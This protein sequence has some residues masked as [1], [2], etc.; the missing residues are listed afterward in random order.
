MQTGPADCGMRVS[1]QGE[2]MLEMQ[3]TLMHAQ[4]KTLSLK[5]QWQ[6]QKASCTLLVHASVRR[7][8]FP[9]V[10]CGKHLSAYSRKAL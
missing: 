9:A 6:Q 3:L 7:A 8:S 4:R 10:E 5:L 2:G 1:G